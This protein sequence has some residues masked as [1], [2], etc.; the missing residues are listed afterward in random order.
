MKMKKIKIAS[1]WTR[2]Q[3][4]QFNLYINYGKNELDKEDSIDSINNQ[5]SNESLIPN[6]AADN[7]R[8]KGNQMKLCRYS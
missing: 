6:H 4:Q 5:K 2:N 8:D 1:L 7:N 3:K